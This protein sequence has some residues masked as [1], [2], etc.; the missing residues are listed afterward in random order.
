MKRLLPSL[1]GKEALALLMRAWVPWQKMERNWELLLPVIAA[2]E[3]LLLKSG[4]IEV[5][6]V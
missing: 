5:R 2:S 1:D 4:D 6:K 3:C